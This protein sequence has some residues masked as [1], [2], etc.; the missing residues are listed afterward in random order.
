MKGLL[1]NAPLAVYIHFPYCK[2]RCP[3]CDYFRA[4]MPK[5]FD[6]QSL[7]RRYLD[8]MRYFADICGKR[9]VTN[10]FFG[11]GTPSLLS[12]NAVGCVLDELARSFSLSETAEITL[13]ANPNSS[14]AEKFFGFRKAGIN[15]LSLGVQ[16][17]NEADLKVLGRTHTL[18]EA[19]SSIENGMKIFPRFS[20]DLIYARPNQSWQDWENELKFALGFGMK[21]ISLYQLTIMEGTAFYKKKIQ[22][23]TEDESADLYENTVNTLQNYGLKR[24]EVSNFATDGEESR[25]NLVYWQGGDYIGL[26]EGAHGR[27]NLGEKGIFT[28]VDGRLDEQLSPQ[29]RAEE[30]IMMGLRIA[31]GIHEKD[32]E[33]GCGL[34][35]FKYLDKNVIKKLAK[36]DLVWYDGFKI[37]LTAKGFMLL[38]E[39]VLELI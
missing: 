28:T 9:E 10:V 37:K 3:Y 24:Y 25:H 31:S 20:A 12:P 32:F 27:L 13:E 33:K 1:M 29:E 23:P 35:L 26:G 30:L 15:R 19:V 2:S 34:K 22:V 14:S 21:H 39:I 4:L 8:D 7:I 11:G 17:L 6:E 18:E 16:A 36:D 38:D 5:G